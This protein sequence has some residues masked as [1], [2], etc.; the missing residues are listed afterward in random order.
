MKEHRTASSVLLPKKYLTRMILLALGG[1]AVSNQLMAEG[2]AQIGVT[3]TLQDY[4]AAIGSRSPEAAY[5]YVDILTPGEVINVSLCGVNNTQTLSFRILDSAGTEVFDSGDFTSNVDC[6]DA[7]DTP[8]M[9]AHKFVTTQA[10]TYRLEMENQGADW[11]NRF[12]IT[13]TS[14]ISIDPDPTERQGRLWANSWFFNSNS[15]AESEATDGDFYSLVP[16]GRPNTNYIWKLDLNN[17]AGYWYEIVANDLGVDAPNSGYST[18]RAG[19]SVSWKFP[20]YLSVPAIANPQPTEP[21]VLSDVRFVDDQGEDLGFSPGTS[22]AIQDSGTFEFNSDV[23][24]N[25][26]I[27]IDLNS[28][29]IMGDAGDRTLIGN[30]VLGLN[31]VTWDGTDANGDVAPVGSY[32]V[33]ISVRMGEYHFISADAETS[34]GESAASDPAAGFGLTIYS[35]DTAGVDSDTLVFWDDE[36]ILLTGTSNTPNGALSSTP[37]GKH[38][39]GNFTSSG[40]GNETFID[41]YVYGLSTFAS[42]QVAIQSDDTPAVGVDGSISIDTDFDGGDTLN[43]TVTDEDLNTSSGVVETVYVDVVNDTTGELEKLQLVETGLDTGVFTAT[44]ATSIGSAG[45]DSDGD[46]PISP[47]DVLTATYQDQIDSSSATATR[48]A[49]AQSAFPDSDGDGQE[50]PVDPDDDN[51]GLPDTLEGNGDADSDGVINSLDLDSDNDGITDALEGINDSDSDGLIDALDIDSDNDGITDNREAQSTAAFVTPEGADA[52]NDGIDNYYD[53]D[54]G[55]V[56][57]TPVDTDSDGTEDYLDSDSDNDGVSDAVEAHDAD[58]NGV[59]DSSINNPLSDIDSDGL[60]DSYDTIVAPAAGNVNGSNAPLQNSDAADEPDWRDA[61]DDGDGINTSVEQGADT[62]SDGTP[63]YLD[64]DSDDDSINDA[65]EGVVDTDGDSTPDFQDTDSDNDGIPDQVEGTADTD[66]DTTANYI[67]PDSDGD[68]IPDSQEGVNDTD[69]DT[70]PDYLDTDSDGDGIP[71]SEEG[72][73]DLD[74]DGIQNFLDTDSDG[75]GIPDNLENTDSDS[76]GVSDS[77]DLDSDNDGIP[78]LVEGNVDTDG[79]LV[80]D[81]LDL[82][83]DN[84][85]VS[86]LL[87]SGADPSLDADQD[88]RLDGTVGANGLADSVETVADSGQTDYDSDGSVDTVVDTDNDTVADFRDLDSDNDGISDVVEAGSDVTDGNASLDGFV[89]ANSDGLDDSLNAVALVES[90]TDSDAT[91]NRLDSDSDNDGIA[92]VIEADGLDND[93][94]GIIDGFSDLNLD[95]LDDTTLVTPL[96]DPDTDIDGIADRNDLDSDGDGIADSVEGMVDTDADL[97]ADFRDSDSDADGIPDVIEGETDTDSDGTEDFRDLD[98]DADNIPDSI[99]GAVDSDTDGTADYLDDDSDQD[100]IP[101]SVEGVSDTDSDTTPNYLDDDSDGDSIP[102]SE[103]GVIDTDSDGNA[104]YIDTDSD[105]DGIPDSVEGNVDSDSD[106]VAD[107]LDTDSDNDGLADSQE[108]VIDTDGDTLPNYRD[109]DSDND[110]LT[111]LEEGDVD[112]DGD[113]VGSYLDLDSDGNGINDADEA[114][115]IDVDGDGLIG[116]FDLDTDNDT[117]PDLI[118]GTVDTDGDGVADYLD[119]DSDNDG[120]PDIYESGANNAVDA[121]NDG[122]TDGPVG[123]NGLADAVETAV[124]SGVLDYNADGAV[125]VVLDTDGDSVPDYRDLD[126]DNDGLTDVAEALGEDSDNDAM[127][128]GFVDVD[129]DGFDDAVNLVALIDPDSDSDGVKDRLDLD[130]DG[131]GI[132]DLREA[133]GNDA[134]ANGLLDVFNDSDSNGRDD[135]LSGAPLVDPDS[136]SDGSVDRLDSDSDGDSIADSVEGII[137]TDGDSVPDYLDLDSDADGIDDSV[138]GTVDTDSDGIENYL[139]PDSDDDGIS[140]SVEGN[141][142]TDGDTVADYLDTDSDNDG[143]G[144][145]IEGAVDTDSDGEADF[146][147]TDSDDDGILD[148]VEGETDTDGDGTANYRDLDSDDDGIDDTTEGSNDTDNDGSADFLDTD[149]DNDGLTDTEEAGSDD[150]GDGIPGNLDPDSDNDGIN[151]IDEG[152]GDSDQDGIAD[153]LDTD[154]DN[155]GIGDSLEAMADTDGDGVVDRLDLDSDNDGITDAIE[156]A[157]DADGDGIPNFRD[158]DADND[159]ILDIAEARVLI[160]DSLALD[161]DGNGTIDGDNTVNSNGLADTVETSSDSGVVSYTLADTDGDGVVDFLDVDSDN[162]GIFDVIEANHIDTDGNG[163]IDGTAAAN[164]IIVGADVRLIDTDR[165]DVFDFRDL[166]SDNDSLPDVIEVIGSDADHNARIDNFTDTNGDGADD[167][168]MLVSTDIPDTDFDGIANFRDRDSDQDGLSDLIENQGAD[169]LN[170]GIVDSFEDEDRDGLDDAVQAL[171]VEIVDTEG[172]GTPDYLDT[173]SDNDGRSDQ[174][175]A[176][177]NDLDSDGVIDAM[178]DTDRDGI[179]DSVDVDQTGGADADGDSIDDSADI[180]FAGERDTDNDGIADRF[181]DDADGDGF[182]DDFSV[183]PNMGAALPD[184]DN[185]GV[186]DYQQADGIVYAGLN[187]GCSIVGEGNNKDPLLPLIVMVSVAWLARRRLPKKKQGMLSVVTAGVLA[188]TASVTA[189]DANAVIHDDSSDDF[190][191]RIYLGL[192]VGMSNLEPDASG[193]GGSVKDNSD[194]GYNFTLGMDF[195][196]RWSAE[197][198]GAQLG[199]A[200][201]RPQGELDYQ[202][203]SISGLYYGL[204][205]KHKRDRRE[206]WSGYLRFGGG[207]MDN[208][209]D[210]PF[211]RK[212]DYHYLLGLGAEY[213][214]E[215]GAAVRAEYIHYDSDAKFAGLSLL[216]RFNKNKQKKAVHEPLKTAVIEPEPELTPEPEPV[217]EPMPAP[218]PVEPEAPLEVVKLSPDEDKDGVFDKADSCPDTPLGNP[219]DEKGCPVFSGV[220]EGVNFE[221]SSAE[222]TDGAKAVLDDASKILIANPQVRVAAMAHTDNQG[223]AESNLQLSKQ[224]VISVVR[225]LIRAG[226]PK[227]QMRALAYGE[228]RP[229]ASND[230]VEGRKR[231]RRVEFKVIE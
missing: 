5:L 45:T 56:A 140:D 72:T 74:G 226:V 167:G 59:A 97:I 216:Y 182:Y 44:L 1:L 2:S 225:Y 71:D 172:D 142:D 129:A 106:G 16:G 87:E 138:E 192:G 222:L 166:D 27:Y 204:N 12:D 83:S 20:Q 33:S 144:D 186:P 61:D 104:N 175:E 200:V 103:E 85:G 185:N 90:D 57:L 150:D 86:D 207:K 201:L 211:E 8:L 224:R 218:T 230:T 36:T 160:A 107:Y 123:T 174:S 118:E 122:R 141:I 66:G 50:D 92:D 115:T 152:T 43:V 157:N 78:D 84:D 67:D 51:D 195:A 96:N 15:F 42:T 203:F 231:N 155:D 134:D 65:V 156:S 113:G 176:G 151:D 23:T 148:S 188:V 94:D 75:D 68:S 169:D 111:D 60:D 146:R 229:I 206:D 165:D 187:G 184:S 147:D 7:M 95:G 125:D 163:R 81:Y 193:V 131:D 180:D 220:M 154:S 91:P 69:S 227:K 6:A 219:V 213:G 159:G 196:N 76:D 82:D 124:D 10:D 41:T 102:D 208:S 26:A 17:F 209:A 13:V 38:A 114:T 121:D 89:D 145:Q 32:N 28:N 214:F 31:Q 3:Q 19:N 132:S 116:S 77:L 120:L 171:P 63:D 21:P 34:G 30:S 197:L 198:Q 93:A 179:P 164:G 143:I 228:V 217:P 52:D 25:Y 70:N 37:E 99:E 212:N 49:T 215:N 170:D 210:I 136:D 173:D 191:K 79:D 46:M 105:D 54:S 221:P 88:A 62:D 133:G 40:F 158:L 101:D 189:L 47:G 127:L 162:D 109:T 110:G 58:G 35:T 55:G 117:I 178:R 139:D 4:S 128:D 108:G 98:S 119:L 14:D 48:E 29:G 18:P 126:S 9:S 135:G 11:F 39:W 130:S 80:A 24:G 73:G 190:Q 161:T 100:G 112:P 137:D 53:V 202:V 168:L 183:A 194:L 199:T 205:E 64:T 177:G 22:A 153:Y 223:S 149:S 181:D